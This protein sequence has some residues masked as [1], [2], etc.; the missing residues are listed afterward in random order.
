MGRSSI[1]RFI[2]FRL[3]QPK[4]SPRP[5]CLKTALRIISKTPPKTFLI[6]VLDPQTPPHKSDLRGRFYVL[7]FFCGSAAGLFVFEL[8]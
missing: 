2:A 4:H 8:K 3:N 1:K 5:T 6:L 7:M